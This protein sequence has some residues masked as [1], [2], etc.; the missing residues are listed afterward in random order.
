M[1]LF[2]MRCFIA[3]TKQLNLTRAAEVMGIT[4]P[5]MSVQMRELER[6]TGLR[7]IERSKGHIAITDAGKEV[8]D[9]FRAILSLYDDTMAHARSAG[10]GKVDRIRTG[11][12]GSLTAFAP[13]YQ[14]F[15][16]LHPQLETMVR[17][18]EW[19]QLAEMVVSGELDVAFVERHEAEA[20]PALSL[21]PFL[22]EH[23]FCAAVC[24]DSPLARAP[25]LTIDQINGE[26]IL[27]NGFDSPSM[28]SMLHQL[29][30]NGI[31]RDH[32]R[33]TDT[34]DDA[35]AMAASGLGVATMPRFLAMAGNPSVTWVPIR[36]LRF[37]CDIVAIW[38]A[39]SM[40]AALEAFITYSMRSDVIEN[41]RATWPA[42]ME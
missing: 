4:Q 29:I 32:I 9:G 27:M 6:E 35:I 30:A 19:R 2:R 25:S 28:D 12:H 5:A 31:P 18:A 3:V 26:T 14:G 22:T 20:R 24:A 36:G 13:L 34:V 21:R 42:A 39:N 1:D 8:A 23:Y 10:R 11:Y 40:R 16:R 38:R 15:R 33:L 37:V 17:I 7:L 41:M